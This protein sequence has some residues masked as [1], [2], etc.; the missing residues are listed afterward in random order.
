MTIRDLMKNLAA[1]FPKQF[2]GQDALDS[3]ASVYRD[4]LGKHEGPRLA[5]AFERCMAVWKY[6]TA[7]KPAQ[8]GEHLPKSGWNPSSGKR[9]S[10]PTAQAIA[11]GEFDKCPHTGRPVVN[12][13]G[14]THYFLD[15]MNIKRRRHS[16]WGISD[17]DLAVLKAWK[18]A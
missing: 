10:S 3:W 7:P 2:E 4:A 18:M 15:A 9:F 13:D 16:K 6:G 1:L 12:L 17:H 11:D 8:I 5:E 14:K